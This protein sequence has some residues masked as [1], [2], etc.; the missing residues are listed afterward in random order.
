M[1]APLA[2]KASA[3]EAWDSIAAARIGIDR[4]RRAML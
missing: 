4:V 1:G 2:D 3:K